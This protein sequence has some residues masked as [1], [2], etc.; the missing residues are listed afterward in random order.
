M[1]RRAIDYI[2]LTMPIF[3]SRKEVLGRSPGTFWGNRNC[4]CRAL[5]FGYFLDRLHDFGIGKGHGVA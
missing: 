2:K 5:P 3:L 1:K 4:C